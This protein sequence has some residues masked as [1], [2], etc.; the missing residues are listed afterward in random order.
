MRFPN[1]KTEKY[2]VVIDTS[3]DLM[4]LVENFVITTQNKDFK[5]GLSTLNLAVSHFKNPKH[6]PANLYSYDR[7]IQSV[8]SI[9]IE[10]HENIMLNQIK[11]RIE[12]NQKNPQETNNDKLKKNYAI[13][14]AANLCRGFILGFGCCLACHK[15]H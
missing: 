4:S 1:A 12:E 5:D 9:E 2:F 7:I 8:N 13:N 6:N 15:S 3:K 14:Y 10:I 11:K